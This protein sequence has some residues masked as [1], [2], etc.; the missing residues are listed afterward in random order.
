MANARALNAYELRIIPQLIRY[1]HGAAGFLP[2][3]TWLD[4]INAGFYSTWPGLTAARVRQYLPDT[5]EVTVMGQQKL[6]R[7][8]ICSTTKP[9]RSRKHKVKVSIVD[10]ISNTTSMDLPGQYPVTSSV[11]HKYIFIMYDLDS[12]FIKPVAMKLRE[13][14][15]MLRCFEECYAHFKA[16]GFV[17]QLIKTNN[18]V[19]KRLIEAFRSKHLD[20]ECVSPGDHRQN[21]AERAI[22]DFKNHF[23]S[24]R[25]GTDESYPAN[26]RHHLL[27]HVEVTLNLHRA[28]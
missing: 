22:Q 11:G 23:I 26:A 1:L 16:A 21:P 2:K 24:V 8:G 7:Q 9:P 3:S 4:A 20:Y 12:N 15:E 10:N 28:S 18:E 25:A 5:N 19:S 14:N 6:I 13:T 27:D 17:A